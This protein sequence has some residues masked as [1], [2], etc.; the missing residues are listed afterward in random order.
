MKKEKSS[1]KQP[2]M[3]SVPPLGIGKKKTNTETTKPQKKE[4][5]EIKSVSRK[6]TLPAKRYAFKGTLS[7]DKYLELKLKIENLENQIKQLE[8][9]LTKIEL[10]K[11]K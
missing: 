6:P 2:E 1:K 3:L 10:E 7:G 8:E 5:I 4:S 9:R 11:K